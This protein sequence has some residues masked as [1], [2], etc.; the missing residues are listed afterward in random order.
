M[1]GRPGHLLPQETTVRNTAGGN[2]EERFLC[3]ADYVDFALILIH[4]AVKILRF[5]GPGIIVY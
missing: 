5:A 3:S 1:S 4:N 2:G